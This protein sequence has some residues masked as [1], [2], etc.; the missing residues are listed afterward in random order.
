MKRETPG[1]GADNTSSSELTGLLT[2]QILPQSYTRPRF[3]ATGPVAKSAITLSQISTVG[4]STVM[5]TPKSAVGGNLS[6]Y[7]E[8]LALTAST[9]Q[10]RLLSPFTHQQPGGTETGLGLAV[11]QQTHVSGVVTG[12]PSL[13]ISQAPTRL[14]HTSDAA[15]TSDTAT[16]DMVKKQKLTGTLDAPVYRS[17]VLPAT[18]PAADKCAQTVR[19]LTIGHSS[20][21]TTQKS[22][23][24]SQSGT[25]VPV[26]E[27]Q[28]VFIGGTASSLPHFTLAGHATH[29][30]TAR[31]VS[32]CAVDHGSRLSADSEQAIQKLQ[33]HDFPLT[34]NAMTQS[35]SVI[36]V[37]QAIGIARG[38]LT[39]TSARTGQSIV[40]TG[41]TTSRTGQAIVVTGAITP[42]SSH[43][44]VGSGGTARVGNQTVF[45]PGGSAGKTGESL[46][47][48]GGSSQEGA[49]V[50]TNGVS[51]VKI[52]HA[53][54][55]DRVVTFTSSQT[56]SKQY[57][58]STSAGTTKSV[59]NIIYTAST[60][61]PS[62]TCTTTQTATEPLGKVSSVVESTPGFDIIKVSS[63]TDVTTSQSSVF[64]MTNLKTLSSVTTSAGRGGRSGS[65]MSMSYVTTAKPV[66]PTVTST[67][68]RRIKM[69][70]QYDL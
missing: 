43:S 9:L 26:S 56:G 4:G 5:C 15:D 7:A 46:V 35:G 60:P 27:G 11:V 17:E 69:P 40:A 66:L 19:E 18:S 1:V 37:T 65:S 58:V 47:A 8:R 36:H 31:L 21:A 22:F 42:A 67:R 49:S 53:T 38:S 45:V 41:G 48:S 20:T 54:A 61:T 62:S 70:K 32:L 33:F 10:Q 3:R 34:T 52:G 6:S 44:T 59:H 23:V 29:R 25:L 2:G 28:R 50:D 51:T 57:I 68:T 14:Q 13:V 64:T 12:A 24:L 63:S 30:P 39:V 55:G 16:P